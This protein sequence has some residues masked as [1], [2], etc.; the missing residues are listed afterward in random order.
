V[1]DLFLDDLP[2]I[3]RKDHEIVIHFGDDHL[4]VAFFGKDLSKLRGEN[5]SSLVIYG[6]VILASKYRHRRSSST[7]LHFAPRGAL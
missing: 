1:P 5:D 2:F 6:V 3:V 4:A 7:I